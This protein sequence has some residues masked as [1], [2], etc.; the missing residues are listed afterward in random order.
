M[1]DFPIA[2]T[3]Y[4][5]GGKRGRWVSVAFPGRSATDIPPADVQV[6]A[7]PMDD[8]LTV[9]AKGANASSW[10]PFVA[11]D[12]DQQLE[13]EPND[14]PSDANAIA[15]PRTLN[16]RLQAAG[17]VDVFKF[18]AAK[19][20]R[21]FLRADTRRISSPADLY[22]RVLDA[23]GGQLAV[24]DDNG[25]EDAQLEFTAPADGT[26][27]L[28]VED[29]HRRGGPPFTYRLE[30]SVSRTD[31][32]LSASADRI[33]LAQGS[34][35]PV[36]MTAARA[37]FGGPIGLSVKGD[38][39][40]ES[41]KVSVAPATISGGSAPLVF[42]APID[43]PLGLH[44][45]RIMGAGSIDPQQSLIRGA[46]FSSLVAAKLNNLGWLP[47]SLTREIPVLVTPRPFFTVQTMVN[48]GGVGRYVKSPLTIAVQREKFFDEEIALAIEFLPQDVEVAVKPIPKGQRS[49]GLE[50][51][52]K[53]NTPLGQFPVFVSG[54]ANYRGRPAKVYG[55]VWMLDLRPAFALTLPA[56]SATIKPGGKA[57]LA[58]K[59]TRLPGF[60]GPI[61]VELKNLPAGVAAAKGKIAEKQD[62]VSIELTADAKAAPVQIANLTAAGSAN[63]GGKAEA[64]SSSPAKFSVAQ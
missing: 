11:D 21:I 39:V 40:G 37:G 4:P 47:P 59:A 42:S 15:L 8:M 6:G 52:S 54:T 12:K 62:S 43:A 9:T 44:T 16:G 45:L 32:T 5:A 58:V 57:T 22:L 48:A 61:E 13:L 55:D 31:Y 29:L 28:S 63:V 23:N 25:P 50:I 17:D 14:N 24:A 35:V 26:F 30:C 60:A 38:A 2:R 20:T 53:P 41:T 49:I 10:V 27:L 36:M 1:G 34:T 33:V 19:G 18:T 51:V 56:E 3:A 46:D 7:N 64:S